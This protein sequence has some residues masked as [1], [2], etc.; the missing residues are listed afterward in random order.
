MKFLQA[1]MFFFLTALLYLLLITKT[2]KMPPSSKMI[3]VC[4]L[5]GKMPF[6]FLVFL[7]IQLSQ[8]FQSLP[9]LANPNKYTHTAMHKISVSPN[10]KDLFWKIIAWLAIAIL[11]LIGSTATAIYSGSRDGTEALQQNKNQ[12]IRIDSLCNRSQQH[13]YWLIKLQEK[14]IDLEEQQRNS[15]NNIYNRI[16]DI[17]KILIVNK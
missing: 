10:L 5:L 13:N 2:P 4:S 3:G 17:Y 6:L 11:V 7:T 8:I 16:D 15:L 9:I 1:A 14:Q 12:D